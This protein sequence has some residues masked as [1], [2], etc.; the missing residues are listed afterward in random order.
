MADT[1]DYIEFDKGIRA[2][3]LT[4]S[5]FTI[6]M[7]ISVGIGQGIFN[8]GLAQSGHEAPHIVSDGLYNVQNATTKGFIA[9]AYIAIPL[10][11]LVVMALIMVFLNVE[12]LLPEIHEK[13]NA[14][15]KTEAEARGEV[16]ISPEEKAAMEEAEQAQEAEKKRIE[17]LKARCEKKGLNFETEEAKYQAK[18]AAKSAKEQKNRKK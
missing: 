12:N 17:E 10:I 15:R 9:F 18:L 6:V 11:C 5:L 4:A 14:R 3:G 8:M 2:D 16:Y 1:L 7:T 13:L